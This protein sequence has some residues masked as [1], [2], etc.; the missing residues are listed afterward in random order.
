MATDPA[1][2]SRLVENLFLVQR[3]GSTITAESR[4]LLD[5][6]FSQIAED[7]ARI[8]PTAPAADRWRRYRTDQFLDLV[9]E[10]LHK[11]Y[12]QWESLVTQ[13][14][15]EAGVQQAGVAHHLVVASLGDFGDKVRPTPITPARLKVIL[16]TDPF[17]DADRG[18][19][20]L[21]EWAEG[22]EVTTRNRIRDQVRLGMSNE[23]GVPDIVRRVR[24]TRSGAGFTGGVW[25][26]TTRDTEAVVR[27]AVNFV[28]NA[29]AVETYKANAQVLA[30]LEFSATLDDRT[31]LEC[32]SLDGQVWPV[33]S[34]D[35]KQ[36]P[37]H[38]SCR[39]V[40]VPRADWA[41]LGLP[42]PEAA[43]RAARDLSGVD[44]DDLNRK[45]SARRRTGDLGRQTR[46][47]SS[48]RYEQWLRGQP[49][50]VQDKMLGKRRAD[51]FRAKRFTLKDLVRTDGEVIPLSELLR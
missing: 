35:I 51:L 25:Q 39:S 36:P 26:A 9:E 1:V 30:G 23:E 34:P 10:R 50:K 7:F 48:V 28:S 37:R 38:F 8:D 5:E 33:D 22:L 43:E 15:V 19:A 24:G 17:G 40:L 27:T 21:H 45:V 14:L 47:P 18:K 44:E 42:E 31:T 11:V 16:E 49:R 20:L 46:V 32:A 13:R 2:V 29:G 12:P 4:A 3:I 41:K 6:L